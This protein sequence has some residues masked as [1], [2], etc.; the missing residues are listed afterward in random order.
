MALFVQVML[1][2]SCVAAVP[3]FPPTCYTKVLS[4]ARE[5]MERFAEVKR[6]PATGY[7]MAHLPNIYVDVHNACIMPKMRTYISLLEGLPDR[8]CV[9]NR[10]VH[11]LTATIRQLHLIMAHKCHGDLHFS[12]DDCAALE[13]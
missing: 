7:C 3:Y 12:T 1:L 2:I 4:M 9:R 6:N 11:K 8:S 5:I 10:S 13:H